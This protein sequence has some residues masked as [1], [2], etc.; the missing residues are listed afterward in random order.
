MSL[1]IITLMEAYIIETLRADGLS[2]DEIMQVAES[3]RVEPYAS[4]HEQLDFTYLYR[5]WKTGTLL[6]ALQEGYT[7][8]Y[9]TFPGL[10]NLLRL[11]FNKVVDKHYQLEHYTI[12]KLQLSEAELLS[13]RQMLSSNWCLSKDNNGWTICPVTA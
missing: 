3:R 2:D 7:I 12:V 4:S 9:I 6:R 11:K 13:V 10:V 5:L 1:V 8:T